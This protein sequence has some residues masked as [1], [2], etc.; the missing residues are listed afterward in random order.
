MKRTLVNIK[1]RTSRLTRELSQ[2]ALIIFGMALG[3]TLFAAVE[4][5]ICRDAHPGRS[6]HD[7]LMKKTPATK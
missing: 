4:V 5:V 2:L 6:I 7:C 3:F 1:L